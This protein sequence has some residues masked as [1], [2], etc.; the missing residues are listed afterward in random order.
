MA[1]AITRHWSSEGGLGRRDLDHC[2]AR[3]GY[4]EFRGVISEGAMTREHI[5]SEPIQGCAGS[6]S[7]RADARSFLQEGWVIANHIL[8][9]FHV[10]FISSVLSIPDSA[11]DRAGVLTYIFAS[12]E[13]LVSAA[14]TLL[15]FHAAIALHE[16]G[17]F[18]EA[19]KL[20]AL[21]D[22]IQ[23]QVESRLNTPASQRARASETGA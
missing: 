8:V 22:G 21:S 1:H 2:P 7:E 18:L 10:A 19:A 5:A 15:V 16:L 13:T 14:F 11:A 9:S 6:A 17:H 12:H 20:R 4:L 23:Q 3:R